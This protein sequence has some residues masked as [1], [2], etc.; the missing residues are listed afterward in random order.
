MD[1]SIWW[2]SAGIA[3]LL[4]LSAFFSGSET[5]LTAVN[6]AAMHQLSAKGSKGARI[7]L[8][9]TED[10]ERLI[11]S[12]LLGNNLVNILAA[13]LATALFTASFG[14]SG[15]IWATLV[16][17]FLVLVFAEVAPKTYAITYPEKAAVRVAPVVQV[18]VRVFAPVVAVV[19]LLVRLALALFGVKT[20]PDA[21]VLAP[22]EQIKEQ[23]KGTIALHQ[24]EGG[25][26]KA[27]RDRVL[28]SLDLT[29]VTL[30]L[31]DWGGP[32]GLGY[33]RRHAD[34]IAGLVLSNT[35]AFPLDGRLPLRLAACRW[36]VFGKLA[37]RGLNAFA[38]AATYMAVE[39]PLAAEVKRGY[40]LPYDSWENRVATHEFVA[41]IPL[42]PEHPSWRELAAIERDLQLFQEH[43]V[44]L[45]WGARD[46]VFTPRILQE[47]RRRLPRASVTT[48][49]D[50]GHY[51]FEDRAQ[52]YVSE[53]SARLGP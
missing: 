53:L 33:A 20:D 8:K 48:F 1:P 36:P 10:N 13:S 40:L 43:P 21:H 42:D 49:A 11:G 6:R 51:L 17:T 23:I 47:W 27:A 4:G 9:L 38:R 14:D 34:A 52:D 30:V 3:A 24:S 12:I 31:H 22:L 37:V 46:W 41:D 32:I 18:A 45:L 16:M 19:R 2:T 50:A 15:V 44:H 29:R 35:A 39:H 5:A 7:A 26:D 28:A 25:V